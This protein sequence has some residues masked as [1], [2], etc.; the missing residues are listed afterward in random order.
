MIEGRSWLGWGSRVAIFL[1]LAAVAAVFQIDRH[2]NT[3]PTLMVYVPPGIGGFADA[4]IGR[5]LAMPAPQLALERTEASLRHRPIDAGTLAAFAMAAVEADD[6]DRA[7]RALGY[8]ASR[9]WRDTYTQIMVIGSAISEENWII[10]A[11]RIDALTRL[12]R[13]KE[14]IFASLSMMLP[15]AHGR[16]AL[17]A[18]LE[19]SNTLMFALADFLGAYPNFSAEV[20][21]TL[22]TARERAPQMPCARFARVT[23]TL[24]A[25]NRGAL[26]IAVWPEGCM[27]SEG[28]GLAF[29]PSLG[30]N[31]PFSWIYPPS[32]GVV[33][34]QV[35]T[36]GVLIVQN[37]DRLR[38]PFATRYTVLEP[39]ERRLTLQKDEQSDARLGAYP[40]AGDLHI[41]L[42]CDRSSKSRYSALVSQVYSEPIAFKV[43]A[44]CPTQFLTLSIS[45]G[46]AKNLSISID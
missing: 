39:G 7:G 27:G 30:E 46:S 25:R 11:Q 37:R 5:L 6:P 16:E 15:S 17:A 33:V 35:D 19:G 31:Y 18:R 45:S 1:V 3:R 40:R 42:R 24:L 34:R 41:E 38:H 36:S 20:A 9:G 43:P 32:P 10:A 14:A 12:Q 26:A 4:K 2:S 13:E 8:A 21:D 23:R 22:I 29:T 44:D 28:R